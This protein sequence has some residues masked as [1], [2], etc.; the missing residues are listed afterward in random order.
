[1][2]TPH[3]NN[4]RQ[5]IEELERLFLLPDSRRNRGPHPN[6]IMAGIGLSDAAVFEKC[7]RAYRRLAGSRVR[8]AAD[9]W[10][11]DFALIGRTVLFREW[12]KAGPMFQRSE[13]IRFFNRHYIKGRGENRREVC[14]ELSLN[15]GELSRLD[16]ELRRLVGAAF[17]REGF[18]PIESY[19]PGPIAAS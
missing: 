9:R 3:S 7:F 1:M 4:D 2:A 19:S 5:E 12:Q 14:R 15:P 8:P 6:E 16:R 10:T 13:P 18:W 11:A 17:R